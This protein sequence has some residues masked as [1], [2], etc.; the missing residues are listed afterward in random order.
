MTSLWKSAL[1]AGASAAAIGAV[2]VAEDT[3]ITDDMISAETIVVLGQGQ[4]YSSAATTSAMIE[5]Q[6]PLTSVL[7]VV[8]NL[9]GVLVTEGDTFGFDDWS[10]G[11]AVRGFQS[12]LGEQQLGI[13]IDGLPNGNS[14]YGGGAKANR[15][16]DTQ[17]LLGIEVSQGTA[18]IASRSNEALGG[19]LDFMTDNPL[20]HERVRFSASMGDADSQRIYGRYDTGAILNGD[21]YAWISLSSQSATD[22]INSS[23]ENQ[24]DHI[25]AK[26]TSVVADIDLTGYVSFDDT[27]EDN[28]Q[29]LFSEADYN[30][31]PDWDQLTAEWTG[32]PY[33]DQL[34][35]KGWSTLRE[36]LF[37]YLKGEKE[38]FD[39][40]TLQAG[41]YRHD[42]DGRGDWVPPYLVNVTDDGAGEAES[43]YLP[44]NRVFGGPF[45]GQIFFVDANGVALEA[46]DGCESSIT[47][48]YGG[49]GPEYDPACYPA[50]AIPVQ[51]YRHTHYQKERTGF[52]ADFDWVTELAGFDN[53]LRGG[54]WYE[55][56]TRYEYR[57]WHK[58]VD[59]RVGYN[60]DS[61]AYWVQYSREFPQTT[62][63]WYVEDVVTVGDFTVRLGAKQFNNEI[64]RVDVFDPADPDANFTL[65]SESDVLFSGGVAWAP[66]MLPGFEFFGGYAENYKAIPDSVL[67]VLAAGGVPDP[68]TAENVDFGVRFV[69]D[70]FRGSA[71]FFDSSF[72]NRLFAAPTESVDGID[73]LEASN[74]GY[75]NGGGIDSQGLE[76]AGEFR[77]TDEIGLF[78]SYT[79]NDSEILG[80]GDAALDAATGV[81]AGNKVPGIPE[82]M[83][84]ASIDW[85]HNA[86]Y[87][88]FS[89]KWVD[90][91]YVDIGN[92]WVADSYTDADLYLGASG[93]VLSGD[94]SGIDLRMTVNNV[95]DGDWLAGISG[96]GAWLSAPRTVV[97]TVTADF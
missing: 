59:T 79:Y 12:N 13:T 86:V 29:R 8:D 5:Q 76:L 58:I 40:F 33:V 24:R 83:A 74:G 28:Y 25:A 72:E 7:A 41:L 57:D 34:Y 77:L 70:R 44:G 65:D 56:A 51:S 54:L 47:F 53:E 69:G 15:Y 63:K 84:V 81:V 27:H 49:A 62:F 9:P 91:R 94:L 50:G 96:G 19:T 68:E 26:F 85:A 82:N 48:P 10:T 87:G 4:T 42:N 23:A 97:F 80:T 64:E 22:W 18:D 89:V 35:R 73:Y 21:T 31:D 1:L 16:I 93:E 36:N 90:D 66:S 11:V 20:D 43:E 52:T 3:Q 46:A 71:T 37:V 88:G 60:F 75:I 95:F 14:N 55:D 6:A 92:T 2:A 61:L 78:G 67:E 32:V 39:G 17:N 38:L 45:L 30:A